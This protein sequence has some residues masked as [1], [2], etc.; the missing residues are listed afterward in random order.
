MSGKT[1]GEEA[2]RRLRSFAALY[3]IYVGSVALL[4][5]WVAISTAYF[6][7]DWRVVL[8]FNRLGEGPLE[9]VALTLVVTMLPLGWM[10]LH[11]TMRQG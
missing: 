10:A 7:G 1:S 4:I 2:A 8:D 3:V 6:N 5:A 9:L 11:E